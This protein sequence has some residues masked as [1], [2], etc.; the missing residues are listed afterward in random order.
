MT[1]CLRQCSIS[2]AKSLLLQGQ[3]EVVVFVAS[4]SASR[5]TRDQF[6]WESFSCCL[7]P[8]QSGV[9]CLSCIGQF[10]TAN[11]TN[12]E[13]GL[14]GY[15]LV[16]RTSI[17]HQGGLKVR[18][19]IVLVTIETTIP[20]MYFTEMLNLAPCAVCISFGQEQLSEGGML[21]VE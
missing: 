6:V 9:N 5:S 18:A 20:K 3:K 21:V 4:T 12:L 19:L 14:F 8:V 13:E 11:T 1:T 10:K 7:L 15:C 17:R 16:R 2:V